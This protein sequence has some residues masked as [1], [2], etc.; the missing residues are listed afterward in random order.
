[1]RRIIIMFFF[2]FLFSGYAEA[3]E[4]EKFYQTQW[5]TAHH[6]QMEYRLHDNTRVDCLTDE[7]AV[8]FD[9]SY[10]W[11]EAVGQSL[12]Y[13]EIT[14]KKPMVVLIIRGDKDFHF[15]VR[16]LILA[17]KY[18]ITVE[19]MEETKSEKTVVS[20]IDYSVFGWMR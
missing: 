20:C 15:L 1:M 7:Y 17:K 3:R 8:E 16:L 10:K 6:G 13:A 4:K 12:Y 5:C 11:A 14:G 2:I 19:T 18:G 9:F